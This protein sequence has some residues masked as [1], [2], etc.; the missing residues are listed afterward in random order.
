MVTMATSIILYNSGQV[1]ISYL[2]HLYI[3]KPNVVYLFLVRVAL[4]VGTGK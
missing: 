2:V 3:H 1:Y 4:K